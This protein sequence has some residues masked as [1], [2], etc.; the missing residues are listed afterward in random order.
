MAGQ[1]SR[2]LLGIK[3]EVTV[4]G[5]PRLMLPIMWD[6]SR[7][8]CVMEIQDLQDNQL[9]TGHTVSDKLA[10]ACASTMILCT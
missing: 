4:V 8:S 9:V 6:W 7:C 1:F 3:Q 5:T 2:C 10:V